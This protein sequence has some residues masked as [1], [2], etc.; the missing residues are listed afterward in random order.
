M[1]SFI[2]EIKS[3]VK[4]IIELATY[5]RLV[6]LYEQTQAKLNYQLELI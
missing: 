2:L 3:N 6:R 1:I 4:L 5:D